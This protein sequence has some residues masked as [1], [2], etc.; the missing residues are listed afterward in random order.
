[1]LSEGD[2]RCLILGGVLYSIRDSQSDVARRG[3]VGK[4]QE[5]KVYYTHRA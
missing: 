5:N 2:K 4:V 3:D 1:M